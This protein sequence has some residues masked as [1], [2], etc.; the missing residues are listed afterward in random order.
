MASEACAQTRF[1][2]GAPPRAL[3]ASHAS[4]AMCHDTCRISELSSPSHRQARI[5]SD[6][7]A[8]DEQHERIG[9]DA[10]GARPP[11]Q[12]GPSHRQ[13]RALTDSIEDTGHRATESTGS[14]NQ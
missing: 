10:V 8:M 4:S 7:Y 13:F 14:V 5:R 11:N 9:Y 6:T 12:R 3:N 2:P 1:L